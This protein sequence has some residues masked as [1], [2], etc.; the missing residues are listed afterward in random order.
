[1]NSVPWRFVANKLALCLPVVFSSAAWSQAWTI[2]DLGALPGSSSYTSFAYGI[3]NSGDIV[4]E[5]SDPANPCCRSLVVWKAGAITALPLPTGAVGYTIVVGGPRIN[6]AGQITGH[7]TKGGD[8]TVIGTRWD[9]LVPTTLTSG[10]SNALGISSNGFV[11]GWVQSTNQATVWNG[12]DPTPLDNRQGGTFALGQAVNA[13]A[14]VVGAS[15]GDGGN[16]ATLWKGTKPTLLGKLAGTTSSEARAINDAGIVVGYG[17]TGQGRAIQW[18]NGLAVAL[19]NLPGVVDSEANG[20]NVAGDVVG[21]SSTDYGA[22]RQPILWKGGVPTDLFAN[23]DAGSKGWKSG[24]ARGIND[25]GQIV[26]YGQIKG[27]T[28]AF[29]M[30]KKLGAT[31]LVDPYPSLLNGISITGDVNVLAQQGRTAR[32]AAADGVALLVILVP[33]ANVGELVTVSLTNPIG[34]TNSQEAGALSDRLSSPGT[35]TSVSVSSEATAVGPMAFVLYRPPLDFAWGDAYNH[36]KERT[37]K[38]QINSSG[39]SQE[40]IDI[41][42]VRPPTIL[43]HGL[44]ADGSSWNNFEP[45]KS[46]P[47][48]VPIIFNYGP[49]ADLS[50]EVNAGLLSDYI[51]DQFNSI[52]ETKHIAVGAADFIGHSM[53]GDVIRTAPNLGEKYFIQRSFGS[54]YIHKLVALGTPHFGSPVARDLLKDENSCLVSY[55]EDFGFKVNPSGAIG[56]LAGDGNGSN[57]SPALQRLKSVPMAIVGGVIS[58]PQTQG[59][60]ITVAAIQK[61]CSTKFPPLANMFLPKNLPGY[62]SSRH[63]GMVPLESA[64]NG[65]ADAAVLI[66][67][68]GITNGGIHSPGT[69][70]FGYTGPTLLDG[71]SPAVKYSIQLLNTPVTDVRYKNP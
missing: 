6:N 61:F 59:T 54:G 58:R 1:M 33:T 62:L 26:G 14:V 67:G 17:T 42:I 4:G 23:S 25:I 46:S 39:G 47:I 51:A 35:S 5:S 53:G 65:R 3:N 70:Y 32:G 29:V 66:W 30:Q 55:L 12:N 64:K 56:D 7:V 21:S 52:S 63:D 69:K 45:L 44:W 36:L 57:M 10:N 41:A 28:H 2:K 34:N 31:T 13:S 48:F 37:I 60:K 43:V 11:A 19:Q 16:L 50:F 40:T 22:T 68:N 18:T 24:V 71:N 38:A 15:N 49:T 20:I 8:L 27:E 9:N